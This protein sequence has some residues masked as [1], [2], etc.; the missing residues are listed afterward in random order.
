MAGGAA[1]NTKPS[2]VAIADQLANGP[3]SPIAVVTNSGC[4]NISVI[5]M[6]PTAPS[7]ASPGHNPKFGTILNSIAV[8]AT[9]QGIAIS[10]PIGL[11]VVANYAMA[12]FLSS[13]Y[14]P[15]LSPY[16]MSPPERIQLEWPSTMPPALP[17]SPTPD[18][19]LLRKLTWSALWS[20]SVTTLAGTA[21]SIGGFQ[22]PTA[23]AIDPD[24]GTNNQ[25]LAVVT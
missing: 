12:P 8:G 3:F 25:G 14:S 17:S 24:R 15:I 13:I 1:T 10:Q 18:Q 19:T 6:N 23:V 5:D 21:V 20:S 4:N 16:L 11:A 9:P 2:S 22:L 7:T